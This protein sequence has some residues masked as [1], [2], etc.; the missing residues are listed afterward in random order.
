MT[1]SSI[2]MRPVSTPLAGG[3]LYMSSSWPAVAVGT[4]DCSLNVAYPFCENALL[5]LKTGLRLSMT[6]LRGV[7]AGSRGT[8]SCP[9]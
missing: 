8:G 3:A 7:P 4:A 9:E 5:L 6:L 2:V 1:T